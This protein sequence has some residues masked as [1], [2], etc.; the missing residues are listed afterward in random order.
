MKIHQFLEHY[1][2]QS[3]PFAVE[4]AQTDTVFKSG[5]IDTTYHPSWQKV[6]G[7][8]QDPST[9]IVFGEKGAGKT[10][11]RLQIVDHIARYNSENPTQQIYVI[12]YDD[13]NP[14]LDRFREHQIGRSRRP[15]RTLKRWMLWDHMD[16]ILMIGVT[17][18]IDQILATRNSM[19]TPGCDISDSSVAKLDQN[20]ARDLLLLAAC[21]DESTTETFKTRWSALRKKL[22]FWSLQSWAA[23][24]LGVTTTIGVIAVFTTLMVGTQTPYFPWWV[25]LIAFIAGWMP[26]LIKAMRALWKAHRIYRNVKVSNH[27]RIPLARTLMTFPMSDLSSQ[28][29]PMHPRTD[30]RYAMLTKFSG[31]L[32][33]LDVTGIIVIVD[34]VDEPHLINGS[35]ELMKLLLWPMLDNK[36]LK[37]SGF[38]VKLLLP[39]E[40]Q[41]F[42]ERENKEFYQRAR[43]DKQNMIPSLQWTSE[44]L[45]DVASARIQAVSNGSAPSVQDLFDE[46]ISKQRIF[47]AFRQLRV[48]RHLF[49]FLYRLLVAHCN[50]YT[51]QEPSYKISSQT[52][53]STLAIYLR[54]QD[55]FDRGLG[56]G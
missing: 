39:I 11:M 31:I 2:I 40:L 4:D 12:E 47:E 7:D 17:S 52:F 43:L 54:E 23:F 33:S 16:A 34:R 30:D 51:D 36:F 13:F 24:S 19:A 20:Q 5:C 29:L 21:Y 1:G 42:I 32:R 41:Q 35:P 18:L 46:S 45:Y 50:N 8:P 28:P 9:S 25:Y 27:E 22:G 26:W 48:P 10:A 15:D 14:Y 49:K 53:E 37:Q 55:A 3:N 6:Y 44:A 56:A 38:G